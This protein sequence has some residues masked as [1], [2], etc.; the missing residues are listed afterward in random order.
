MIISILSICLL[1]FFHLKIDHLRKNQ[2]T[3]LKIPLFICFLALFLILVT[4]SLYDISPSS[5][6]VFVALTVQYFALSTMFW[7]TCIS[8]YTWQALKE[9][10]KLHNYLLDTE[11]SKMKGFY[12]FAVVGPFIITIWTSLIQFCFDE[13]TLPYY[14]PRLDFCFINGYMAQF[15][16]FQMFILILLMVNS[17]T[18]ISI[19]QKLLYHGTGDKRNLF[20]NLAVLVDIPLII[21]F[22]WTSEVLSFILVWLQ[23]KDFEDGFLTVVLNSMFQVSGLIILVVFAVKSKMKNWIHSEGWKDLQRQSSSSI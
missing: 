2:L 8:L 22:C 20:Y 4:T 12:L 16:H 21:G 1:I 11:G 10:S 17:F 23:V 14:Y 18:F 15:F 7:V 9:K 6:C 5:F 13:N 19:T 3:K